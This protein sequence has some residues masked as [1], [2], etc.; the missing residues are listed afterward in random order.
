[1]NEMLLCKFTSKPVKKLDEKCLRNCIR[2]NKIEH[3]NKCFPIRFYLR[4]IFVGFTRTSD[5]NLRF[6][7]TVKSLLWNTK[8]SYMERHNAVAPRWFFVFNLLD[9]AFVQEE[10]LVELNINFQVVISGLGNLALSKLYGVNLGIPVLR[11]LRL[12][13]LF[14]FTAWVN[15][16]VFRYFL[17]FLFSYSFF[18][19]YCILV[20]I[21]GGK[22][23][24]CIPT[25]NLHVGFT[26]IFP[27][28]Y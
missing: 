28:L 22:K 23:N 27:Q 8:F 2:L 25:F 16:I 4:I 21:Y 18:S 5:S 15:F 11:Q 14:K 26:D 7:A 12:M 13:R 6:A 9:V 3:L 24:Y 10:K 1:M 20:E 17:H 19:L